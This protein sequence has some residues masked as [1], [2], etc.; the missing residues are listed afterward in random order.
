[1]H[2]CTHVCVCLYI[3]CVAISD[4]LRFKFNF[5]C[6]HLSCIPRRYWEPSCL[7]TYVSGKQI[8]FPL[9]GF[10]GR[11]W[12]D[13]RGDGD[14]H[15]PAPPPV[16]SSG[17]CCPL[18]SASHQ[19]HEGS[20][21]LFLFP[22]LPPLST[23]HWT[24]FIPVFISCSGTGNQGTWVLALK[25]LTISGCSFS[26]LQNQTTWIEVCGCSELWG[27]RMPG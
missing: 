11:A 9:L 25:S 14:Y 23:P 2:V 5:T 24:L 7:F 17:V 8:H 13:R 1:M 26:L 4:S 22:P 6:V 21:D 18:P 16:A 19:A 27:F 15:S 3:M 12:G 10:Q 20:L